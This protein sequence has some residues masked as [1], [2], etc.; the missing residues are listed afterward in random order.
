[1]SGFGAALLLGVVLLIAACCG[2]APADRFFLAVRRLASVGRASVP[3]TAAGLSLLI[4]SG[5]A[6]V[7][8]AAIPQFHDEF[9]YLLAAD[10]F[11]HGRLTNPPH[12]LAVHLQ[13][14][15]VL[16][17][18]TY[19]SKYPPG[20]GLLLAS[21]RLVISSPLAA[22][23]LGAALGEAAAAAAVAWAL[24]A[25]LPRRWALGGAL[26]VLLQPT[27]LYWSRSYWGG[28][29]A[30]AGGA[31][32]LGAVLRLRQR[33]G[34][35][36]RALHGLLAGVGA[37]V[38]LLC[39]PYEGLAFCLIAG[40]AALGS[41]WRSGRRWA[42]LG[43]ATIPLAGV[44]VL[45]AMDNLRVTHRMDLLPYMLHE[46]QYAQSPPF[47]FL[48]P[49]PRREYAYQVFRDYY[50]WQAARYWAQRSV[51]GVFK[52]IW[53]K[54]GEFAHAYIDPPWVALPLLGWLI[55]AGMLVARRPA[56]FAAAG[57]WK[58]LP[59]A[60]AVCGCFFLAELMPVWYQPH[61]TA[62]LVAAMA[63]LAMGG[64]RRLNRL[65]VGGFRLGRTMLIFVLAMLVLRF[66]DACQGHALVSSGWGGSR[67]QL[68]DRLR[69]LGDKNV[70]IVRRQS[71]YDFQ[72][73]WVYNDADID[74][75]QV[76]FVRDAGELGD[77]DNLDVRRYYSDRP[78][79][80]MD[81]G[82]ADVAT[83]IKR[84]PPLPPPIAIQGP[85]S[86]GLH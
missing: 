74:G 25:M 41:V 65:R 21:G 23:T 71:G 72:F 5:L 64:G 84:L 85:T 61:Y 45:I 83:R 38:L 53:Q 76:V 56:R 36:G 73:E 18:P 44:I 70:V 35:R 37:G 32:L 19:S 55:P 10:T 63:G 20:E 13:T 22:A 26:L 54:C 43:A 15:H 78:I 82:A 46:S 39:R 79:W 33:N 4:S 31:L 40:V 68:I 51:A 58:A 80:L 66:V 27:V 12:P 60:A 7:G 9:S 29:V 86:D 77:P 34:S 52:G 17:R 57:R 47:I 6:L 11:A 81:V 67:L 28:Q 2:A 75:S 8:G 49:L 42:I 48:P 3:L 14:F 59:L 50:D 62:P 69:Q 30:M 24:L 1:V 16:Q